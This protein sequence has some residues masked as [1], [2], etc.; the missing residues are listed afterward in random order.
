[1]RR[2]KTLTAAFCRT[3]SRPGTY[4]D[5]RGGFGLTLRVKRTR[6]GRLSKVWAQR[7]V[8]G[9]KP[10]YL[11]LGSYPTVTL[12]EARR[13][14]LKNRREIEAGRDP[15][16]GGIPTFARATDKVIALHRDGW[17]P[18]SRTESA[19][20]NGFKP[21]R[22]SEARSQASRRDHYSGRVSCA[23]SHMAYG[24]T[25]SRGST[26]ADQ[27]SHALGGSA[28]LPAGRRRR[29]SSHRGSAEAH[30]RDDSSQGSPPFGRSGSAEESTRIGCCHIDSAGH[31]ILG[32]DC[33]QNHRS[34]ACYQVGDRPPGC[35]VDG[36]RRADESG[37]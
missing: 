37:S 4:G 33:C 3:I 26:A 1:M 5:G 7:V 18:G 2:P 16:G 9:G 10:T 14:A 11:G 23:L 25:A 34:Q 32:T 36:P 15:R 12:A 35:S 22:V 6:N 8:I 19:W 30:Q 13:R 24:T 29:A 27:P 17:K 20:R 31:R 28:G 21:P